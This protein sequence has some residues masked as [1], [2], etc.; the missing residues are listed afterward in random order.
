M[1][2]DKQVLIDQ[3]E[4]VENG[5]VQVRQAT[6]ITDNGNQVSRTFHRWCIVPSQDYSD[7]EQKVQDICRVA[8]TPEVIAAYKAQQETNRLGA[9]L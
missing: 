5:T 4:V 7:Q 1:A 3:I 9:A 6:I 2:L 8:H